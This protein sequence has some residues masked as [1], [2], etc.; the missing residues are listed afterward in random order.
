MYLLGN[1]MLIVVTIYYNNLV[2]TKII[3]GINI[4]FFFC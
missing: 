3:I 1:D 4:F 2:I